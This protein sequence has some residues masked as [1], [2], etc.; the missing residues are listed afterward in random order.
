MDASVP[1]ASRFSP[2]YH[3]G[4]RTLYRRGAMLHAFRHYHAVSWQKLYR[5]LTCL[6]EKLAAM[7]KKQ[8][9]LVRMTVPMEIALHQAASK[10]VTIHVGQIDRREGLIDPL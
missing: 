7:T 10:D 5:I 8:F 1:L 2:L 9:V 4:Y 6:D 3:E